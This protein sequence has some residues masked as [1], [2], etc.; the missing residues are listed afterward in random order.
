[1]SGSSVQIDSPGSG[2]MVN[3]GEM[4]VAGHFI[5]SDFTDHFNFGL[6]DMVHYSG[7]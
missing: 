1:M 7:E 3:L 2:E 6:E 4:G 5:N